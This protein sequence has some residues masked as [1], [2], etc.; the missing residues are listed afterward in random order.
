MSECDS[1][2][3]FEDLQKNPRTK[4][5]LMLQKSALVFENAYVMMKAMN[6]KFNQDEVITP[7]KT[8]HDIKINPDISA[9]DL[10]EINLLD[11]DE[12]KRHAFLNDN[13]YDDYKE[14]VAIPEKVLSENAQ[15]RNVPASRISRL[16][17]FG[18]LGKS[19]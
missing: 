2:K 18:S 12:I 9:L 3:T 14:E 15:E 19:S 17:S 11:R 7:I 8:N 6:I 4:P 10:L 13:N 5:D 1:K 16:A